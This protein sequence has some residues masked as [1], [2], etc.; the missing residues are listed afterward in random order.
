MSKKGIIAGLVCL[1]I[2]SS[3]CGRMDYEAQPLET[4]K[5]KPKSEE[6]VS[7]LYKPL[8]KKE[9]MGYLDRNWQKKGVQPVQVAIEN[10][11]A[12]SMRFTQGGISLPTYDLDTIKQ[13]AHVNTHVKALGIGAP[14]LTMVTL[15]IIGL[16]FAPATFGLTGILLPIGV[17]S[18]G[19]KTASNMIK[20]DK[21]LDEDYELKYLHDG[22]IPPHCIVEG[23]IFVPKKQFQGKFTMKFTD[24]SNEESIIVD[25]KRLRG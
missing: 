19:L 7:V 17:G 2:F 12:H 9:S 8:T 20:S 1:S 13:H 22:V 18:L 10:H 6:K 21:K 23:I 25:P 24:S 5:A 16:A 4:I 11:T 15:G 14:S 3:G